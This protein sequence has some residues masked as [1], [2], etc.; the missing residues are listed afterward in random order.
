MN[1]DQH[2]TPA[3]AAKADAAATVGTAVGYVV[4][5]IGMTAVEMGGGG[6]VCKRLPCI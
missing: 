4:A 6:A 5:G 2:N 3:E 1:D